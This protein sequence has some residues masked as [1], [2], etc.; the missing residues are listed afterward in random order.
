MQFLDI[1]IFYRK[2]FEYP[3]VINKVIKQI[4]IKSRPFKSK[5]PALLLPRVIDERFQT[6]SLLLLQYNFVS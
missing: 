5:K 2:I 6:T 3:L 4:F 1:F